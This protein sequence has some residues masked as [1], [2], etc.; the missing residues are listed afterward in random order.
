FGDDAP[1]VGGAAGDGSDEG[2]PPDSPASRARALNPV[3]PPPSRSNLAPPSPQPR[4]RRRTLVRALIALG[5]VLVLLVGGFYL[6]RYLVLRQYFVAVS[7]TGEIGIFQGVRGSFLGVSLNREVEGSCPPNT[8]GCELI[9]VDDLK[10]GAR[11]TVRNG[12]IGLQSKQ[13]AEDVIERLRTDM[14]LPAC[15]KPTTTTPTTG[16]ARTTAPRTTTRATAPP[17]GGGA[18]R[19]TAPRTTATTTAP[20]TT[21]VLVPGVD[22]R[23]AGN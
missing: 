15:P 20:T 5:V 8:P 4:S 19:T 21:R 2:P 12:I 6:T 13:Q 17:I 9:T 16:A 3:T 10:Q 22:C 1:I 14:V 23:K 18:G 11:G 7:P